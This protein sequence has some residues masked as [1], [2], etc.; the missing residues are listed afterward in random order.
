VLPLSRRSV[1]YG[2]GTGARAHAFEAAALVVLRSKALGLPPH[3]WLDSVRALAPAD[4]QPVLTMI[5]A[6]PA[7]PLSGDP[8]AVLNMSGRIQ[9]RTSLT[10]WRETLQN[11]PWSEVF[12]A[13]VDVS[14]VCAFGRLLPNEQ[15]FAG[16]LDDVAEAPVYQYH[17]G[18]WARLAEFRSRH[19]DYVDADFALGR[20]AFEDPVRPDQEEGL[21]RLQS[22][23]AAFPRSPAIATTMATC[24]ARGRNGPPHSRRTTRRSPP[25][26]IIPRP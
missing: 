14:L 5:E 3:R 19:P 13:Y 4:S 9:A 11:G 15:S 1:R 20:Y 10:A 21:K 26:P 16:P 12:R 22:A 7:D 17:G 24:T 6:I 8:D 25:R 2:A 23:A 18:P